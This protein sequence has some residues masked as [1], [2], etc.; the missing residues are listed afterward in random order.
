MWIRPVLSR[1]VPFGHTERQTERHDE[2]NSHFSKVSQT[3]L[4]MLDNPCLLFFPVVIERRL[5]YRRFCRMIGEWWIGKDFERNDR[6]VTELL[7]SI[8]PEKV[9]RDT[10]DCENS[11]CPVGDS[12]IA[13][14]ITSL[15]RYCNTKLLFRLWL[16]SVR[17]VRLKT[18]HSTSLSMVA[19]QQPRS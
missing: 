3:R 11:K 19:D 1:S 6:G 5:P 17:A 8:C 7:P 9:W 16:L 2:A 14:P 4:K 10:S 13:V 18:R 12:N 15:G